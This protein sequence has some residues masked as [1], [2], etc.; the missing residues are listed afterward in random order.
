MRVS[1]LRY[2]PAVALAAAAFWINLSFIHASQDADLLLMSLISIERWTPFYWGDN[3]Y[4]MLLPLL[5]SGVRSYVPNL[6]V[7]TQLSIFAA[8]LTAVLFQCFFLS[9]GLNR[10]RG[11]TARNLSAALFTIV[12]AIFCF[13]SNP[14]SIQIFLLP[15]PYFTSLALGLAGI[16][17]MLRSTATT[18]VRYIA[19]AVAL[20][21]SFWVN[22]SNAPVFFGL[23]LLLP[24]G[25]RAT[26]DHLRARLPALF[27]VGAAFAAAYSYSL[28]Y[29]RLL[30][31]GLAS[32]A[33]IPDSIARMFRNLLAGMIDARRTLVVIV[34][35]L[36][37]AIVRWRG[38][39]LKNLV[40]FGD[41][42]VIIALAVC[43]AAAIASTEW[44]IRNLYEWRYWTIAVVLLFLVVAS[45]LAD[46]LFE[47]IRR[48]MRS[49]TRAVPIAV[50]LFCLTI[51]YS[52]GAPSIPGVWRSLDRVSSPDYEN[53]RR[54]RCTH[55]V[56]D[57]WVAWRSVFYNRVHK[58]EPPLWAVTLRSEATEPQWSKIPRE[59]RRY[60]GVCGDFMNNYY[61]IVFNLGPLKHTDQAG[62]LCLFQ[63]VSPAGR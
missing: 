4:G 1:R 31:T 10:E 13:R 53:I 9:R 30:D 15:H 25:A 55:M 49:E 23:V 59:E 18:T 38:R 45:F 37:A 51:G 52:F 29:P 56:G 27:V 3:R 43:F 60:C 16:A 35:A 44:V 42:Q 41:G 46:S 62:N 6:M 63:P 12:L 2:V 11:F 54:L 17:A 32:P 21:L 36:A 47:A 20:L 40:S 5:A 28:L 39:L 24:S 19:G 48:A 7:Q 58:I 14:R 8:L 26:G 50:L 61:N 33:E 57:Y 34:A 22:W